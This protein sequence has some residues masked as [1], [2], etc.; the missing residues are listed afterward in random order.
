MTTTIDISP[1]GATLAE[2]RAPFRGP[3]RVRLRPEAAEAVEAGHRVIADAIERGDVVYAVNTGFGKLAD[4]RISPEDLVELQRRLIAS[5]MVGVG[6]PL[7]DDV[8]RAALFIKLLCLVQGHSGVRR[9]IVDTIVAMLEAD[10]L[11]VV[12]SQGSVGASGDLA[13]LSHLVGAMTGIGAVRIQGVEHPATEGLRSVGIDPVVLGPKEGV[14]LINGTQMSTALALRGLFQAENVL[15]A[16][17]AAGALTLEATAGRQMALDE[18]IQRIRRQPGQIR[19]A[20]ALRALV[21]DSVVLDTE[22]E[23]RRLQDPYSLRCMPQVMGAS[24]DLLE[25]ASR[26]L[27]RESN[28]VS[29]NPL[30]FPEDG[31]VLSGGNFHGQPVAFAAD[32][33]AMALCE[34]GS[35]AER[36]TAMLM[37]TSMS[38]LPPF[39]VQGAGLNSGF[40]MAQVTSAALVAE[41]RASA[42]PA[43]VDSIPTSAGQE[44]HVSMATH[45]GTRLARMARNA[46]YVVAIELLAAAQGSDL[47]SEGASAPGLVPVYEAVRERA[48]R[49]D[50]DRVLAGEI[51]AVAADVLAG[52]YNTAGSVV[53]AGLAQD[54][55]AR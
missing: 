53:V 26:V 33:I 12:P 25:N 18:R 13:P 23:G 27:E 6:D 41:N 50:D 38:G 19:T 48:A 45:A 35:L 42:F 32:T 21:A 20:A 44:D 2:L 24:L 17:L 30:M 49:L 22:F 54:G 7:P 51:E 40:L 55:D 39:L 31:I 8:V 43:S 52:R 1:D 11:P 10:V 37:D 3:V 4:R 46:A 9:V 15:N 36:R 14:A 16:G 34:V 5:H 29:D 28:A 47:R